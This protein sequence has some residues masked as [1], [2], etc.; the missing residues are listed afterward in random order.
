MFSELI[1]LL[2]GLLQGMKVR[3]DNL[4]ELSDSKE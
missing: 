3:K 1:C 4:S 2:A